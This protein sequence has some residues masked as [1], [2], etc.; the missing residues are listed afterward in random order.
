MQRLQLVAQVF[1]NALARKRADEALRESEE[2]LSLAADS[3]EAGL[4]V[5]DSATGVFWV[6][7]RTR[8]IF[9]YC[10]GRGHRPGAFPGRRASRG[11]GAVR[12]SLDRRRVR[13]RKR[14]TWST[15]SSCRATAARAGSR[16]AGDRISMSHRGTRSPDGR[17][18]RHHRA[19]TRRGALRASRGAPGGGCR[20][21]RPRLLRSGLRHGT[22]YVGRPIPRALRHPPRTGT[23]PRQVLEFWLEHLHPDDRARVLDLRRQLHDGKAGADLH[24]VSLPASDAG[25]EVDPAPGGRRRARRRRTH[26]SGPT[27][28]CATS[29][30]ASASR[31]RCA[32]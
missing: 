4:W 9:G 18:D 17:L 19:Q 16:P 1:A 11:P 21:R 10:A 27:A 5:L 31:R 25:G 12:E 2:R 26:A 32:T 13:E 22:M 8:T 7:E 14:S 15:G 20:T 23:W 3:A 28:S 30:S 24:R 29:P 6:T